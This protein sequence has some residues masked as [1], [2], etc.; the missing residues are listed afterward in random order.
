MS[1]SSQK[2]VKSINASLE[3]VHTFG[4]SSV[5]KTKFEEGDNTEGQQDQE[6]SDQSSPQ[7]LEKK[8]NKKS[9]V[10]KFSKLKNSISQN[11]NSEGDNEN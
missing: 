6:K 10:A 3:R 5:H 1:K 11:Q 9:L 7:Q 2:S 4:M 8:R